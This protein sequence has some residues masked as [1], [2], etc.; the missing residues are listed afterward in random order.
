MQTT[1]ESIEF[2]PLC[3]QIGG[4]ASDSQVDRR[5][6]CMDSLQG[7]TS[8]KFETINTL[9]QKEL[10]QT[11]E[12]GL[13][14]ATAS[15]HKFLSGNNDGGIYAFRHNSTLTNIWT[16]TRKAAAR[17]HCK[18]DAD[19]RNQLILIIDDFSC[20]PS[21]VVRTVRLALRERWSLKER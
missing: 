19:D 9:A 4:R 11:I 3:Y 2:I 12:T 16:R 7:P 20:R 6:R 17:L 10:T 5:G 14:G 1:G 13:K 18:I 21:K 15:H 8:A